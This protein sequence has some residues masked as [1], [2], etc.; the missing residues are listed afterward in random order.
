MP[1][2][3]CDDPLCVATGCILGWLCSGAD[4]G[5]IRGL[6]GLPSPMPPSS[7]PPG[8]D[9]GNGP[10]SLATEPASVFLSDV[11]PTSPTFSTFSTFS[12]TS[13]SSASC[14][15]ISTVM[16]T[17]PTPLA[18]ALEERSRRSRHTIP[19][20]AVI[21]RVRTIG[22]CKLATIVNMPS[23]SSYG[24]A[25]KLTTQPN[26]NGGANRRTYDNFEKWYNED[27][28]VDGSPFWGGTVPDLADPE[29]FRGSTEHV[30]EK[31][32]IADFIGSLL[33]SGPNDFDCDDL[34]ALFFLPPPRPNLLR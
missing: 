32:N 16:D 20:E 22:S 18:D 28:T 7:L 12:T 9:D 8:P 11:K 10:K 6:N 30:W 5:A 15:S 25:L 26:G 33:R 24:S 3:G 13:A 17:G 34:N 23:Y 1:F 29:K 21:K 31:S 4:G 2:Y 14:G 27:L 19:P